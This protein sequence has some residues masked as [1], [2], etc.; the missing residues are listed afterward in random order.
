MPSRKG[1][2]TRKGPPRKR[3]QRAG[4]PPTKALSIP[5]LKHAFDALDQGTRL[6]L[7]EGSAETQTKAF[8][9]LW[10]NLFHH[11][12]SKDAAEAYLAIK[13]SKPMNTMT[14]RTNRHSMKGGAALAGAPLDYMTRPG[15]DGV[16]VSVPSYLSQGLT[17][18]NQINQES[19]QKECGITDITP[20]VPLM[21]GSNE[22]M[23][24]GAGLADLMASRPAAAT[25]PP[26]LFQT[27]QTYWSGKAVGPSSDPSESALKLGM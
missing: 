1:K 27:V 19:L 5:E 8:Q 24:G 14:R 4:A 26:N 21:I 12:V 18:Y 10:K 13:R 15:I 23:K 3:Q 25:S 6:L 7:K 20:K 17:F 2:A 22:V 16:H 9:T 11:P